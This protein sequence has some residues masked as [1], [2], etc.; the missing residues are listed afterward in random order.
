MIADDKYGNSES[1]S[2]KRI[3]KSTSKKESVSDTSTKSERFF[4]GDLFT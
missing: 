3:N 1:D 2:K 4:F